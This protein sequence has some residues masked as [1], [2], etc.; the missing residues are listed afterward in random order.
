MFGLEKADFR[1]LKDSEDI[2]ELRNGHIYRKEQKRSDFFSISMEANSNSVQ[3]R[4]TLTWF[5]CYIRSSVPIDLHF[6][7]M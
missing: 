2:C 7:S 1:T 5:K 3:L 6:A 4:I